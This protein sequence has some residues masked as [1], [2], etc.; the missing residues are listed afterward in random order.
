MP[1]FIHPAPVVTL[2][3]PRDF[4]F[5]D[6]VS[7][8]EARRRFLVSLGMPGQILVQNNGDIVVNPK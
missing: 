2:L 7:S 1:R 8:I 3:S 4:D 6:I 5:T